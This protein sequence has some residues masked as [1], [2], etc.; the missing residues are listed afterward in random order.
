[1]VDK[2]AKDING[3][4]VKIGG[5]VYVFGDDYGFVMNIDQ[6]SGMIS[7]NT[8]KSTGEV[9]VFSGNVQVVDNG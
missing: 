3:D 6:E 9:I 8:G 4:I 1:M 2:K 7:V 5:M